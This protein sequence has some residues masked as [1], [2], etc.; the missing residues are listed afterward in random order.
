MHKHALGNKV[1]P[2]KKQ[3]YSD[4]KALIDASRLAGPNEEFAYARYL[5]ATEFAHYTHETGC[6]ARYK[7]LREHM[8]LS[9]IGVEPNVSNPTGVA[10]G[11]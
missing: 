2:I 8:G 4:L 7:A 3:K 9:P 11:E 6:A 5:K 10:P 1:A